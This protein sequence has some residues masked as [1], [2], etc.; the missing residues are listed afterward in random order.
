M[1]ESRHVIV[2]A[3][4]AGARAAEALRAAGAQGP[5]VLVGE[6]PEAPYER[7]P[8]SK[9]LLAGKTAR[10]DLVVHDPAWYAGHDVEL[11]TGRSVLEIDRDERTLLLDGGE[12][13][14]Y[15]RLLL[16]TGSRPRPLNV[17]GADLLGVHYLRTVGEAEAIKGAIA[18]GGPV[19]V[20]GAGWIGLE[21]AAAARSAGLDV[22]L[23]ETAPVPLF[24]VMG[25]QVGE[26][27][28]AIHRGQGVD[29]RTGVKVNALRGGTDGRV[30]GVELVDGTVVPAAWVMVGVGIEPRTQL[31]ESA[32]LAV[33]DGVV[34][35]GTLRTADAHIWAAG[36]VANAENAWAGRRLRVE[37]FANANDQGPFAGRSMAGSDEKW[38]VPP[39]FWSDQYDVGL[40][41]RGWA[42]PRTAEVVLRGRPADGPWTAFWLEDGRVA[43]GL[44]VNAWDDAD[45]VKALVNDRA[46]VDPQR[47]ADSGTSW[48]EVRAG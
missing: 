12:R 7:P 21:V 40:E 15:D 43:A 35:D 24:R 41:Y 33:D 42:D 6:E 45:A 10:G 19:A 46:A 1:A 22:T 48:D 27:F 44:H 38:A 23:I 8:L 9:D 25:Q 3:G 16:A 2:G 34:V 47:L 29:V 17:P 4:V 18:E 13:L 5:V 20:I 37:H 11:R 31:A 39:F 26:E 14:P 36:D 30:E 32:G 28:A